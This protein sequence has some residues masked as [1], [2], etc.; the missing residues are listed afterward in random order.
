L[1]FVIL[2]ASGVSVNISLVATLAIFAVLVILGLPFVPSSILLL[3][4]DAIALTWRLPSRIRIM[5]SRLLST[6]KEL[7]HRISFLVLLIYIAGSI[8][9]LLGFS[10]FT[11]DEQLIMYGKPATATIVGF[12]CNNQAACVP[13]VHFK[14]QNGK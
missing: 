1:L 10:G 2:E 13:V 9:I 12:N 8:L 5:L 7:L 11:H 6:P 14:T 3:R 4:G